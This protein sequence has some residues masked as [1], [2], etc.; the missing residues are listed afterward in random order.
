MKDVSLISIIGILI[1]GFSFFLM[2]NCNGEKTMKY[3]YAEYADGNGNSYIVTP[4][5]TIT[6]EYNPIKPAQSSSG[7]YD[8][9]EYVKKEISETEYQAIVGAI[10]SAVKNKS[11]HLQNRPLGSGKILIE[12]ENGKKR[13]VIAQN[14][15]EQQR[16]EEQLKKALQ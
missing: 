15:D 16:I 3:K 11:V 12:T 2:V 6:L 7:V 8:G 4:G 9:G 5:E 1:A 10:K 14:S 13:Y